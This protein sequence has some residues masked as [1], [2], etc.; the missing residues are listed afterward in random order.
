LIAWLLRELEK[1]PATVFRKKDLLK[2]SKEQFEKLSRNGFLIYYQPEPHHETYPC[3]IPCPNTC[4]MEVVEM[5][6]K[7]FAI[8][9][10]DTEINPIPLTK[11][12]ISR[13]QVRLDK[14]IEAI[15]RANNFTGS[16]YSLT[17]RLHFVGERVVH[18]VN[19]AFT[20]V[21]FANIQ[22]AEA[23]LLSLPARI[24]ASYRRTVVV[25]P[26]LSL[27]REPIYA[28][29]IA[30]SIFPVTL[31]LSL[32]LRDFKISYLAALRTPLPVGVSSEIPSLTDKQLADYE[33]HAYL[34][35]DRLYIPGTYPRERSNDIF[36]NG[37]RLSLGDSLFALLLRFVVELTKGEGGWVNS[38]DLAAE[39]FIGDSTL[40]QPY[41][42]LRAAL[43]GSLLGKDGKKFI[44]ASRSRKYRISTYPD[45]VTYDKEG[46]QNHPDSD[47]RELAKE[48]P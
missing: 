10:K 43:A 48:L 18:D 28:K 35:H 23:Y 44:E 1:N 31:P 22:S 45:F 26:S 30:A 15:R 39:G 41:S 46:L 13:Y 40:Y 8:C 11:D 25:T 6:G 5:E 4:P 19:T 27:A 14:V 2:R 37:H 9:P 24:P 21:L 12:D 33:R 16:S 42:N 17:P 20:L 7:F 47:I 34:C 36:L 3:S 32:G 38:P 29:L